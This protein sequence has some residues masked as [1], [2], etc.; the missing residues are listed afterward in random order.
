MHALEDIFIH[1]LS[2]IAGI[3]G[4][5]MGITTDSTPV[6]VDFNEMAFIVIM[7]VIGGIRSIRGPSLEP[8]L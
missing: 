3:A 7:V 1:Y 6:M 2:G 5:F 8:S 4:A